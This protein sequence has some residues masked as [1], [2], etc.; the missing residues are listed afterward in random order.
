MDP[1][2][3]AQLVQLVWPGME[4]VNQDLVQTKQP[5]RDHLGLGPIPSRLRCGLFAVWKQTDQ[6]PDL[7]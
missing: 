1:A 6:P 7:W 3:F 5:K 2:A 4:A